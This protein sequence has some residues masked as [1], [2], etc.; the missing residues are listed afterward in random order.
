MLRPS[1][2]SKPASLAGRLILV[3]ALLLPAS[4][5]SSSQP[6]EAGG[7]FSRVI[8]F[9]GLIGAFHGRNRIY[10][11]ANAYEAEK[12]ELYD[13]YHAKAIEML[14]ERQI[15][16]LRDS[17]VSAFTKVVGLIEGERTAMEDYAESEKRAARERFNDQVEQIIIDR[18]LAS[19]AVTQ[20]LGALTNGIQSSQDFLDRAL[21]E[22]SGGGGGFMADVQHVSEVAGRVSMVGGVIGG[23]TG[24]RIKA[25]GDKVAGLVNKPRDEIQAGIEQVYGEL[26]ELGTLVEDLKARGVTLTPSE[27]TREVLITLVTGEDADPAMAQIVDL[28]L[29]RAGKDGTFRSRA[30]Q[31]LIANFVA[32]CAS[33]GRRL[34]EAIDA[35]N[36]GEAGSGEG[37][38]STLSLCSELDLE[39]I[40]AEVVTGGDT[41]EVGE[42]TA[43]GGLQLVRLEVPYAW[44]FPKGEGLENYQCGYQ[45]RW[46]IA[47][48]TNFPPAK[49]ICYIHKVD[50]Y[51]Y[52]EKRGN[53]LEESGIWSETLNSLGFYPD[54]GSYTEMLTCELR[55][56]NFDTGNLIA[57]F[58]TPINFNLVIG[59]PPF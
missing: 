16:S 28:L 20:V 29:G 21:N 49:L 15:R 30:R 40:A 47:Y 45:V 19:T 27:A 5:L 57:S 26:G 18:I 1:A 25:F 43:Q 17:Q 9:A 36:G 54:L 4:L 8:P 3:A 46:D 48:N 52:T 10:R 56:G 7:G 50:Y 34:R 41:T 23:P 32:R 6:A 38:A 51:G 33:M 35:L 22:L 55:D 58:E 31:A 42:S 2:I 53:T 39:K 14:Q 24:A 12:N 13:R 59:E 11:T 37:N 44:C